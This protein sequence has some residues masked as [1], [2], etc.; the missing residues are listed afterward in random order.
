MSEGIKNKVVVIT[1]TSSGLGEATARHLAARALPWSSGPPVGSDRRPCP[2]PHRF[3]AQSQGRHSD[4][5]D[6]MRHPASRRRTASLKH[7]ALAPL[8]RAPL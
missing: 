7:N 4:V 6:R 5:T 8:W 2:G 3:W 1:G